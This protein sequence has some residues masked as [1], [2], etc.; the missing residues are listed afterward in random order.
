MSNTSISTMVVAGVTVTDKGLITNIKKLNTLSAKGNEL[1]WQVADIYTSIINGEQ[2]KKDFKSQAKFAKAMD[3]SSATMSEMCN[4]VLYA[5]ELGIDR[6]LWTI[7]KVYSLSKVEDINA[8]DEFLK[9]KN[10]TRD[11]LAGFS[12]R[13][14]KELVLEFN[15]LGEEAEAEAEADVETEEAEEI[16]ALEDMAIVEWN[17]K[18]FAIP[19]S[20]LMGYEVQ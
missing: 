16:E 20:V 15:S 14:V 5:D 17:G 4:A 8:F 10:L 2:F 11:M 1:R 18:Q 19:V 9:G 6:K 12:D 13:V 7:G 3:I